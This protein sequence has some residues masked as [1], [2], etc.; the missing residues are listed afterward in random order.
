ML[1]KLVVLLFVL[2]GTFAQQWQ[3]IGDRVA[4]TF[5]IFK[6]L[7]LT[8]TDAQSQG[9][10]NSSSSCDPHLGIAYSAKGGPATSNPLILYYTEGNQLAGIGIVHMGA[11]LSSQ[12]Q[13]W[14]SFDSSSNQYIMNVHFRNTSEIC[15]GF[16]SDA[17]VGDTI[18]INQDTIAYKVPITE[19]EAIN[20]LWTPGNCISGMGTHYAFDLETAPVM[21]YKAEQTIP[22]YPM[23]MNGT[24]SAMLVD[25]ATFQ[26]IEPIGIW[27]GPFI[28][29][30]WCKNLCKPC[31]WD[32]HLT[33]SLHFMFHDHSL[34]HCPQQCNPFTMS[35]LLEDE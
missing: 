22:L 10:V 13:W 15:T 23:Y 11:P 12:S 28:P 25:T 27:E 2:S 7:P 31:D 4:R 19:E 29:A 33:S 20:N 8:A 30:V 34:N 1:A 21:S 17:A 9:W 3:G 35:E 6:E 16:V 18:I 32:S 24:V 14:Q 5:L 26:A